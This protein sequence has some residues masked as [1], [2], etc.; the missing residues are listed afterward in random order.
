MQFDYRPLLLQPGH[1]FFPLWWNLGL[2]YKLAAPV[3]VRC[4]TGL[5]E[6]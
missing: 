2:A 1:T 3:G 4:I 5:G 6:W